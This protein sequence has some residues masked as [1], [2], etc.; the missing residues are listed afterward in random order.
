MPYAQIEASSMIFEPIA[1]FVCACL[2]VY[3]MAS[4]HLKAGVASRAM[5]LIR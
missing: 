3:L 1:F 5:L 2:C 4:Q